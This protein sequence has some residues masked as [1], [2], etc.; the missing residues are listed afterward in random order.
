MQRPVYTTREEWLHAAAAALAPDVQALTGHSVPALRI[1]C[2]FPHARGT[3]SL[4]SGRVIG[5]CWPP[6]LTSDGV[7]QLMV[8]PLDA[9]PIAT[10]ATLAHEI[11][12]A[13]VGC[14][15]GHN[16]NFARAARAIGLDGK[17]TATVAGP[18]FAEWA[19]GFVRWL[20]PYPHAALVIGRTDPE[21]PRNPDGPRIPAPRPP[22]SPRKQDARMMRCQCGACGYLA[23]V[24]RM[25]LRT[26]G[27]PLCPCGA[28]AMRSD[29]NPEAD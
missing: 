8:T 11:L 17:P 19:D 15:E 27:T 26:A 22:D 1:A 13:A 28:G 29:Y 7:H 16:A 10:L 4:R 9:D 24:S 18:D 14:A 21:E 25:W 5:E 6:Q 20:G 3:A 23:R 2:S 12:H